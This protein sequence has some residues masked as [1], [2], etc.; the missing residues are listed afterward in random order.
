MAIRLVVFGHLSLRGA[1]Y[2]FRLFNQY[3]KGGTPCHTVIQL[4]IL[5]FGLYKLKQPPEKRNDWV[6][7]MDHSIEF[8]KKKC[9]LVLGIPLERF[10]ENQGRIQHKDMEVLGIYIEDTADA[11][12]VVKAIEEISKKT[13][14]PVQILSD[15]GSNIKK[16]IE[17]FIEKMKGSHTIRQTY[18]VTHKAGLI[19]KKHLKE[20]ERWQMFVNHACKTKRSLV[21]TSLAF[22]APSRPKD[23]ARWLNLETYIDWAE[24]ILRMSTQIINKSDKEKYKEKLAWVKEFKKDITQWSTLLQMLQ[25]LKTEVKS[26]GFRAE[27]KAN[28]EKEISMLKLESRK[29]KEVKQD[30]IQYIEEECKN[31]NGTYPGCSD[32]IESV[33]GK[34]KSFSAKSPMK[35]IGKA[36]LTIPAFTSNVDFKEVKEAMETVS[37]KD[38][39]E[40]IHE[41]LGESLFSKRKKAFSLKKIKSDTKKFSEKFK[42]VAGF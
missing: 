41:N 1:A 24:N 20:D 23:K 15:H 21:H 27:T 7:V 12:S 40:W 25:I 32:I 38:V 6:Y 3:F 29:L 13:G 34:Y 16:G 14:I 10:H 35:E 33:F 5:R 37:T 19:L 39:Q 2:T 4:W 9:L 22:I 8:G 30:I 18:D 11:A 17:D 28:F 36:V 26:N 42:K 31:L